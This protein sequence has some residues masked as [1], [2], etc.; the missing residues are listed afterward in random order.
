MIRISTWHYHEIKV[1]D[2]LVYG[3]HTSLQAD[4]NTLTV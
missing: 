1:G 4:R 3:L 2:L